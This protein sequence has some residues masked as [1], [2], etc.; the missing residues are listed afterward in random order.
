MKYFVTGAS[1]FIGQSLVQQLRERNHE[2]IALVRDPERAKSLA[3]LD[4]QLVQGDILDKDTMR[5]PMQGVDGLFHV[6]GW[7]ALGQSQAATDRGKR[8]NVE[9]T[10][11]VLEL[12]RDLSIPKGVYTSTLAVNSDTGG[13]VVD[14]T[15]RYDGPHLTAYDESKWRAH[16]EVA[17]PMIR[18]G[19][20]LVIVQPG[21][22]YGPGDPS[23]YGLSLRQYLRGR[24]G[25]MLPAG[26][27][28]CPAHVDDVAQGH[29]L[30]M[31]HGRPGESYMI[32]A[33]PL[34]YAEQFRLAEEITGIPAPKIEIPPPL[35]K[36]MA[37]LSGLAETLVTLPELYRSETLRTAAGVTYLGDN[38]KAKRDL[39]YDPRSFK[40]GLRQTLEYEMRELEIQPVSVT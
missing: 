26:F 10:R 19:L 3:Q 32:C 2:V 13:T 40:E 25:P 34:S 9:G 28:T 12:M 7:Y 15:Y 38:S 1:G 35:F 31:E 27:K 33:D 5:D 14:E 6:A 4:V 23:N 39:G 30:A 37:I 36:A 21:V 18:A 17:E 20:P 11:N 8:I 29:I 22:V 24:L 16:H